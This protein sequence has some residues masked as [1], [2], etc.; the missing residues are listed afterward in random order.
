MFLCKSGINHV[1]VSG[2]SEI[3]TAINNININVKTGQA[4]DESNKDIKAPLPEELTLLLCP[5]GGAGHRSEGHLLQ[6]PLRADAHALAGIQPA[7]RQRQ[8]RL[9]GPSGRGAA[10]LHGLH[11]RTVQGRQHGNTATLSPL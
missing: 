3:N 9:L 7:G 6:D 10:L 8:S 2:S 5:Q 4:H 1:G 11:L